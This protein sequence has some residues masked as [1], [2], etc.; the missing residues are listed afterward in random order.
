M[1]FLFSLQ[2][3]DADIVLSKDWV[4]PITIAPTPIISSNETNESPATRKKNSSVSFS[5]DSSSE[6]EPTQSHLPNT[7]IESNR[8]ETDKTSESRKN[9]VHN[10]HVTMS[11]NYIMY[12]H[13]YNRN[14]HVF[15]F[16]TA[17]AYVQLNTTT[18]IPIVI[19]SSGLFRCNCYLFFDLLCTHTYSYTDKVGLD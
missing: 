15:V 8:E 12:I 10:V 14:K 1:Y 11:C 9:K 17:D 7:S 6:A 4:P 16:L 3:S 13:I 19:G 5:L 18:Y 2:Y